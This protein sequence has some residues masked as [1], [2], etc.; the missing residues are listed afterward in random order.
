MREW[1][2]SLKQGTIGQQKNKED[3]D[4]MAEEHKISEQTVQNN[5]INKPRT[6]GQDWLRG[7]HNKGSRVDVTIF[8]GIDGVVKNKIQ[9]TSEINIAAGKD[10]QNTG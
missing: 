4:S 1:N 9:A 5:V 6:H 10:V 2:Q 3:L 7:W 8:P